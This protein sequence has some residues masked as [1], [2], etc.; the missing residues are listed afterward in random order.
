MMKNSLH[1]IAPADYVAIMES[2]SF[3]PDICLQMVSLCIEDDGTL[4]RDEDLF[5]R[6]SVPIGESGVQ[7]S[8]EEVNITIMD[9]DGK[10]TIIKVEL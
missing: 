3:A 5:L 1:S 2:I 10:F 4:E 8:Q 7:V 6:L 9:D